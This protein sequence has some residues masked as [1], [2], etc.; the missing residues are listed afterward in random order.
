MAIFKRQVTMAAG[1][2]EVNALAG[3]KFEF[4]SRP[5]VVTV[6]AT[7][8][9]AGDDLEIDL[10]LGN[11]VVAEDIN[12]NFDSV[13]ILMVDRSR[14]LIGSGVGDAG[15]RIQLRIRNTDAVATPVCTVLVE[16]SELA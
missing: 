9:I 3:S 13:D 15:D 12:P 2:V 1:G 5:S 10:T 4:L 7:Q 11:V 6:W 8:S 14:D 16:I